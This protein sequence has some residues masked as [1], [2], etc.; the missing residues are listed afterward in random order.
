[1]T[2][3]KV[4][5]HSHDAYFCALIGV[6]S[7]KFGCK[8]VHIMRTDLNY[9]GHIRSKKIQEY[10]YNRCDA[11]SF[12]SEFIKRE[13]LKN[14]KVKNKFFVTYSG[15]DVDKYRHTSN[16]LILNYLELER[17]VLLFVGYLFKEK[18]PLVFL[19]ACSLIKKHY[20]G[21]SLIMIGDGEM[22][23]EIKKVAISL[24]I[25]KNLFM[26]GNIPKD[27]VLNYFNLCDVFVHTTA[28]EA[29]GNA[30]IEAMACERPVVASN[31]GGLP[32][33]IDDGKNGM[34]VDV[35]DHKAI[36]KKISIILKN[37]VLAKKISSNARQKILRKFS[38]EKIIQDYEELYKEV[39]K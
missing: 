17:P 25:E 33:I 3:G 23:K 37:R 1:M 30:T 38:W 22:R 27:K 2:N 28:M 18:R 32:E 20:P 7:K 39:L 19:R 31:V 5:V 36:A 16:D 6:I 8:S 35:G 15:I 24:G 26:L 34:L 9:R 21:M 10:I 4:I 14:F 29:L 12:V 11:I 13:F